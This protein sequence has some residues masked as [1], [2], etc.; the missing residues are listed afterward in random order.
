MNEYKRLE[1][2]LE[3]A[4]KYKFGKQMLSA[5]FG[6]LG[7]VTTLVATDLFV[8]E[9]YKSGAVLAFMAF[10]EAI[11]CAG[12]YIKIDDAQANIDK[13]QREFE[14]LKQNGLEKKL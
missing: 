6:F 12:N 11:I 14:Y 5:S 7:T 2:E 4:K 10:T 8:E 3:A 13:I 1:N 9:C